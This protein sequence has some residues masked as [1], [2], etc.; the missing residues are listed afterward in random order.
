MQIEEIFDSPKKIFLPTKSLG[1]QEKSFGYRPK[2][3]FDTCLR[4]VGLI[5][6]EIWPFS[7]KPTFWTSNFLTIFDNSQPFFAWFKKNWSHGKWHNSVIMWPKDLGQDSKF[8]LIRYLKL[9]PWHPKD[10][11]SRKNVLEKQKKSALIMTN[12][13]VWFASVFTFQAKQALWRKCHKQQACS[14]H[15]TSKLQ[16]SSKQQFSPSHG[17]L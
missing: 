15:A 11:V 12:P 13:L 5:F 7:W 6:S 10:L 9:F 17:L 4:S 16:A 2:E 8:S 14:K 3:N 1:C